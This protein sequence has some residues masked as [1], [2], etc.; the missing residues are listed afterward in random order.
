MH[1]LALLRLVMGRGCAGMVLVAL[2]I[3]SAVALIWEK[4]GRLESVATALGLAYVFAL[5]EA[6]D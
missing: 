3:V 5:A 6:L 1:P 4:V 2:M